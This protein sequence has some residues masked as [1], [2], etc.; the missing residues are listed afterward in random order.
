MDPSRTVRRQTGTT[1]GVDA[2]VSLIADPFR[3]QVNSDSFYAGLGTSLAGFALIA[4]IFC[5]LRPYNNVV[6]APRS[7]HADEKHAPPPIGKGYLDWVSPIIKTKETQL[8]EKIGMDATLFLK[9]TKMCRNIFLCVTVVGCGV[10]IPINLIASKDRSYG[11]DDIKIFTKLTPTFVWGASYWA[12]IVC[13]YVFDAI[14]CFFLWRNYRDVLRLRRVYFESPEYQRS[15]HSRTL[16]ITEIPRGL[17][18]DEGLVKITEEAKDIGT[19]PRTSIGRNVKDLPDLVEEHEK[20]VRA[21]ESVLAKY[22]KNPNKLPPNRPV[23]KVT[24]SDQSYRKGQK[25]DAIEYLTSRIRELEIEVKEVRESVDK[26]NAMPFGFASYEQISDAHVVAY[27]TRNKAPHKTHIALAPKPHDLIWKNLSMSS[28]QRGWATF[29]NNIWV[30][31][32][33]IGWLVPNALIAVFLSSLSNLGIV[34]PAF[35]TSLSAHP[36]GWAIFQGVVAPAITSAFYFFLPAIFRKLSMKSGDMS[37]TSRERHVTHKLYTF[38]VINNLFLFSLFAAIW[39]YISAVID[40][41]DNHGEDVWD[42]IKNGHLFSK[43]MQGLIGVSTYWVTWLLQRNLGAAVD[44]CQ[45]ITLAWGSFSRHFLNPTPRELIELSAP[46]PFEYAGYYNYFLFYSTVAMCFATI[47]PLVLPITA[48]Y[49]VVDSYLKKYLLL[50]VFITK[51][52]SGGQ[53]WRVLFNRFVFLAFIGN[54]VIAL[55]VGAQGEGTWSQLY[56]MIPLPFLLLAFKFYCKKT[57]DDGCK[58]YT[59]GK[60][61]IEAAKGQDQKSKRND[62]VGVR[63][64]H[65]VLYKPLITPMVSSKS[66]HLLKSIYS[67]RTADEIIG[68]GY[69][70]VYMDPMSHEQPGKAAGSAPAPFEFVSEADMD[71]EHFKNRPE[72]RDEAGGDGELYGRPTDLMRRM[73]GSTIATTQSGFRPDSSEGKDVGTT[74]APGYQKTPM[75]PRDQSPA[76]SVRSM[77]IGG[78]YRHMRA[79]ST[80]SEARAGLLSSAANMGAEYSSLRLGET[81]PGEGENTSYDYFRR[82]RQMR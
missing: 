10:I 56:S 21:L 26:R 64:G 53:F 14:I 38:F 4:C 62:R 65:P 22:L 11:G 6:Y 59:T 28:R 72:F 71:F 80:G 39:Q 82:G 5:V 2:F 81:P 30:I 25:V 45:L 33:T 20:S 78:E 54:C 32:L 76:S 73:S 43:G 79:D 58:Y 75:F 29:M 44:L 3:S 31:A 47:Q 37:K 13:A 23:Y 16:L 70:D 68:T 24:K 34:W 51:T 46:Q 27:A 77:D 63:F 57:F 15:L 61:D 42:A 48:F 35:Q 52:E 9:F 69:S 1:S 50:Y 19:T 17:R 49:F 18:T 8:V 40:A 12:Y 41:R 7:K 60:G 74:Y 67:G 66:Q 36:T 55:L